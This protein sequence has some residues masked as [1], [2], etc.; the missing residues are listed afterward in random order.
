MK[1][2]TKGQLE[3]EICET[4]I[5]FEKEFMGRGPLETKAYI[6]D[7]MVLVRLK[8]VLTQAELKL[9]DVRE[10]KDG[11]ELVK[12]IRITLLEQGRPLLEAAVENI[13]GIKVKSLHTD[14]STVTGERVILFTMDSSVL[15]LL[16]LEDGRVFEYRSFSGPGEAPGFFRCIAIGERFP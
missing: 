2:K 13:L 15:S 8:N 7:G 16:A 9:A 10:S 12:R 14:I 11:R 3:A 6:I 5:K 4:V 1:K